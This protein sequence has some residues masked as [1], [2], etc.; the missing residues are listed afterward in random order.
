MSIDRRDPH[1]PPPWPA[2]RLRRSPRASAPTTRRSPER[3]GGAVDV[4]HGIAETTVREPR[5]TD[6]KGEWPP[7]QALVT[8]GTSG[9]GAAVA[10]QLVGLGTHTAV[11]GRTVDRVEPPL[12]GLS[13]DLTDPAAGACLAAAAD[14]VLPD[15]DLLVCCAGIGCAGPFTSTLPLDLERLVALNIAAPLALLRAVLPGMLRRGSGRVVLVGS[16]A[17]ALGVPGESA[18]SATKSSVHMLARTLRAELHGTGVH[19]TLVVPGVVD[20]PFFA[21]R[22]V[23]YARRFPRPMPAERVATALLSATH[24]TRPEVYVPR[25]LGVVARFQA[26]APG[27]Y[28]RLARASGAYQEPD[29]VG[30]GRPVT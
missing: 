23:P 27:L 12:L 1:R 7:A 29:S 21:R 19:V 15:L 10:A 11:V 24:W 25:W 26:L 9:I 8:G 4:A 18:Y 20:T 3:F 16:I 2:V 30:L 5:T 22:G 28:D 14:R 17:G 13:A 6:G